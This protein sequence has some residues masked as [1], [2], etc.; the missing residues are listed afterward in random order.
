MDLFDLSGKVALVAG[1]SRGLGK[2]MAKALS[3]HN[4]FVILVARTVKGLKET[5]NEIEKEG[6]KGLALPGD[7]STVKGIKELL[8][9]IFSEV[10]KV[11][12]LVNAVGTQRRK[13]A[14]DVDEEDW[15][16]VINTNLKGVYFLTKEIGKKMVKQKKGKIILIAS[17]TS[18]IGIPNISIYGASKGG[19]ASLTRHF[20]VEWARDNVQV[21]AIAPGY[22]K[23]EL[24]KDLF[25]QKDKVEWIKSRIPIGRIGTPD[26]LYGPVI[27]FSSKASDYVTGQILFVDGG[28]TAA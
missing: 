4:A 1:A 8:D 28:W 15:D 27:F 22:F 18:K 7:L 19:I 16:F 3:S 20:A 9:K 10:K 12:I 26:D 5:L 13:P 21:N 17:L 11:D 24:T 2:G 25:S 6:G 23:T 14:F